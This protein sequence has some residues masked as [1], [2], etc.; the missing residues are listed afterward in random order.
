MTKVRFRTCL[1]NT[2]YD[3][4]RNRPGYAA[5]PLPCPRPRPSSVLS[6]TPSLRSGKPLLFP[7]PAGS[8]SVQQ[9]TAVQVVGRSPMRLQLSKCPETSLRHGSG[10]GETGSQS[11]R[12]T[13]KHRY[14]E[15]PCSAASG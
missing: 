3:A 13:G 10:V 9:N 14:R 7:T 5:R 11:W 15:P 1:R 12:R 4:L 6:A 2:I 8:E